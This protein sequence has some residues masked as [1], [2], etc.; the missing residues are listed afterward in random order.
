MK[1]VVDEKDFERIFSRAESDYIYDHNFMHGDEYPSDFK[2]TMR[3][4]M[5][6]RFRSTLK[7]LKDDLI[8]A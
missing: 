4:E 8:N 5:L 2:K 3:Y 6:K 1:V 7:S